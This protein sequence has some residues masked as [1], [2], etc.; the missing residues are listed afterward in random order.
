LGLVTITHPF[1]PLCGQQVE[2]IRLRQG[3]DPDLVIRL[4]NGQHAALAMSSTDYA[5]PPGLDRPST[6]PPLLDLLAL[7]E[8]IER[9][10]NTP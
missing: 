10:N 4:P 8:I 3:T 6:P 5:N 9:I 1:H 2:V 7:F